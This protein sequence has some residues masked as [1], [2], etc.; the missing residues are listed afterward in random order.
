MAKQVLP[1]TNTQVKQA[2]VQEKN[3]AISDGDGLQ[4]RVQTNG[5]KLWVLKY[6]HPISKK[7]TNISF[8]KYPDVSLADARSRRADAKKLLAN[9][10]DP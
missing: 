9:N 3:Y 4:L 10:I 6:S 8:G 2:K 7:R 5:S 1:L